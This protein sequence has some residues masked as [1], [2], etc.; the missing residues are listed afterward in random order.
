M[1][2]LNFFSMFAVISTGG[3]QYLV[4]PG[5]TVKVEKLEGEVG[6]VINV[7]AL[8]IGETDGSMVQVGTPMVTG[9]VTAQIEEQDRAAKV[10]VVKYKRKV[11]YR[12]T[13]GHRQPYTALKITGIAA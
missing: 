13:V 12:R 11:R 3:K 5:T 8:M 1:P 9:T 6:A 2:Y 7:P 4:T 10:S